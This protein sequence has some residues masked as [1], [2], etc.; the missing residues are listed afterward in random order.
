ML[1]DV[2]L[3][4]HAVEKGANALEPFAQN[5]H[6]SIQSYALKFRTA[7]S[8]FQPNVDRESARPTPV[9]RGTT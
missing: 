3:P 5:P 8:R 2:L 6:E 9:R 1:L 4:A 7:L